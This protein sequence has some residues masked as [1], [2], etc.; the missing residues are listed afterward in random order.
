MKVLDKVNKVSTSYN[1]EFHFNILKC[2]DLRNM[3][4]MVALNTHPAEEGT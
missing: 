1:H 2:L 4:F 3:D